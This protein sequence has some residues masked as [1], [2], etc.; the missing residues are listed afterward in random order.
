MNKMHNY[1]PYAIKEGYEV[2]IA[3]YHHALWSIK[4]YFKQADRKLVLKLVDDTSCKLLRMTTAKD[5]EDREKCPDPRVST[6]N[7]MTSPRALN[8]LAALPNFTQTLKVQTGKRYV[9]FLTHSRQPMQPLQMQLAP[10]LPWVEDYIHTNS[11][12]CSNTPYAPSSSYKY[13]STSATLVSSGLKSNSY[14]M[15]NFTNITVS[16]PYCQ[17][18]TIQTWTA[19]HQNIQPEHWLQLFII[20]SGKECAQNLMPHR[21][22]LPIYLKSREKSFLHPSWDVKM[23]LVRNQP[24]QKNLKHLPPKRTHQQRNIQMNHSHPNQL[25]LQR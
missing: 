10:L 13:Q 16:T 6:E 9:T 4:D 14:P 2:L 22:K 24:N 11:S 8:R 5:A 23:T 17:G 3:E 15:M 19:F 18:P 1:E 7:L 20:T 12:F 21:L 25:Q